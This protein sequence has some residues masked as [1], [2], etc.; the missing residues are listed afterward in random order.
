MTVPPLSTRAD[1][2]KTE[3]LILLDVYAL[4]SVN[5]VKKQQPKTHSMMVKKTA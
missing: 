2:N 4:F 3:I 1:L 5:E